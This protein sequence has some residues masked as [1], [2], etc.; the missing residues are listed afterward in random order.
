MST[1]TAEW[2][3]LFRITVDWTASS[4]AGAVE[5]IPQFLRLTWDEKDMLYQGCA[6]DGRDFRIT[7]SSSTTM[8]EY[9]INTWNPDTKD[10]EIWFKSPL[11]INGTTR[12]YIVYGRNHKAVD[13]SNISVFD[14]WD[15]RAA[16]SETS[17]PSTNFGTNSSTHGNWQGGTESINGMIFRGVCLDGSGD[18]LDVETET[19]YDYTKCVGLSV[20]IRV[21]AF[22]ASWQAIICKGDNEWRLHRHNANNAIALTCNGL[23]TTIVAGTAPVNDG[24]WHTITAWYDGATL[25]LYVDGILDAS[26][27]ATGNIALANDGVKLGRNVDATGRDWEGDLED[28]RI[29]G[30]TV[31][32]T[33]VGFLS[34]EYAEAMH[35]LIADDVYTTDITLEDLGWT[36]RMRFLVD[37]SDV[38]GLDT[39]H[40]PVMINQDSMTAGQKTAYLTTKATRGS[41]DGGDVRF[42]MSATAN[43]RDVLGAY[44]S[45]HDQINEKFVYYV[46]PETDINDNDTYIYM[47]YRRGETSQPPQLERGGPMECFNGDGDTLMVAMLDRRG[48]SE[49]NLAFTDARHDEGGESGTVEGTDSLPLQYRDFK[50]GRARR[51][52]ATNDK[53]DFGTPNGNEWNAYSVDGPGLVKS[54]MNFFQLESGSDGS[55]MS[56]YSKR[57][58]SSGNEGLQIK[59]LS[60]NYVRIMVDYDSG[61]IY[62]DTNSL[63]NVAHG[64][65]HLGWQLTEDNPADGSDMH[66]FLDGANDDGGSSGSRNN[67]VVNN[68]Q[69][70]SLGTQHGDTGSNQF[71]GSMAY[72]AIYKV[73][74][75]SSWFKATY[76]LADDNGSYV[77]MDQDTLIGYDTDDA[78]DVGDNWGR[79]LNIYS[80]G[81]FTVED[82]YAYIDEKQIP[83]GFADYFFD[84]VQPGGGDIVAHFVNSLVGGELQIPCIV[85]R[86]D[87]TNK[88]LA[89]R[90]RFDSRA[91]GGDHIRLYFGANRTIMQ[92][93]RGGKFGERE[94]QVAGTKWS[95]PLNDTGG[96]IRDRAEDPSDLNPR[97]GLPNVVDSHVGQAQDIERGSSQNM[98][99]P[100]LINTGRTNRGTTTSTSA[101]RLVD[102]S[103]DFEDWGVEIGDQVSHQDTG[104]KTIVEW[105]E[106]DHT[107]VLRDD[108]F[109]SGDGYTL[110]KSQKLSNPESDIIYGTA[111]IRLE[112]I[113]N[114]QTIMAKSTDG[115]SS[116]IGWAFRLGWENNDN[117]LY[118]IIR[119]RGSGD[120]ADVIVKTDSTLSA[121][122]DYKISFKMG[123][124]YEFANTKIWI[125][126]VSQSLTSQRENTV[127]TTDTQARFSLAAR[128]NENSSRTRYFDGHMGNVRVLFNVDWTDDMET[129]SYTN[130]KR[131]T[132][133]LE[134]HCFRAYKPR[135][136]QYWIARRRI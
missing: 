60:T 42:A 83:N 97:N 95:S 120:V 36:R 94:T 90:V 12:T 51:Y 56:F 99:D 73:I 24:E 101:G 118:T 76:D 2:D 109:V 105:I 43:A 91:A 110:S 86:C 62:R 59:R 27:A 61:G 72:S 39:A 102:T 93:V 77:S 4:G 22:N 40:M 15:F 8:L 58:T 78:T 68:G 13:A 3:E 7:D 52:T 1:V 18:Y 136:N 35:D 134:Q 48:E 92:D 14:D 6:E 104:E 88:K 31:D 28:A 98:E 9:H 10:T 41:H 125:N 5:N 11:D 133:L 128:V 19:N 65:G 37:W 122:T 112:S 69:K 63:V 29:V 38:A 100:G 111:W 131:Y 116:P 25:Y 124:P 113:N 23:T 50:T 57:N 126:G 16:L 49:L 26:V 117:K 17:S 67:M 130:E 44:I 74:R 55:D 70:V 66:V 54:G 89:L 103:E 30:G 79:V 115:D 135:F 114:D 53:V 45:S 32:A 96:L 85:V 64:W 107:L 46:N 20:R 108:L 47:Y 82:H 129:L 80:K 106:D 123:Y 119:E 71:K 75:T 121:T 81:G 34:A 21:H 84:K 33:P 127:G 132:G 87:T